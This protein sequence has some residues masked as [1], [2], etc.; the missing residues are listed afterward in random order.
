[1]KR[2]CVVLFVV[3]TLVCMGTLFASAQETEKQEGTAQA[4]EAKEVKK[5]DVNS[6]TRETLET[7]PDIGQKLAQAIIDNRPYATIEEVKTKVSGI[8]EKKFEAIKDLIEAK[9]VEKTEEQ[10]QDE[11]KKE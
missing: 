1:M 2:L 10:T 6:A 5:I 4:T 3:L 9:P 7:L 8:G 11:S